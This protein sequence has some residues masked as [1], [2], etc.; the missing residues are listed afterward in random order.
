MV[1]EKKQV[2]AIVNTRAGVRINDGLASLVALLVQRWRH[3]AERDFSFTRLVGH[4]G[5]LLVRCVDCCDDHIAHLGWL[6]HTIYLE[7]GV[8]TMLH[9][10]L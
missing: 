3:Y 10:V 7:G 4:C 9:K 5:K 6:R 1:V 2:A 8:F